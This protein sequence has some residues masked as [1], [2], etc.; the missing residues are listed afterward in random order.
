MIKS[1]ALVP[2]LAGGFLCLLFAGVVFAGGSQQ[3]VSTVA[4]KA[5]NESSAPLNSNVVAVTARDAEVSTSEKPPCIDCAED[6]SKLVDPVVKVNQIDVNKYNAESIADEYA[7][8]LR[9]SIHLSPSSVDERIRQLSEEVHRNFNNHNKFFDEPA[10]ESTISPAPS[11]QSVQPTSTFS[12]PAFAAANNDWTPL[13]SQSFHTPELPKQYSMLDIGFV[14]KIHYDHTQEPN[15]FIKSSVMFVDG[16]DM[17]GFV[18]SSNFKYEQTI[19]PS[20][21]PTTVTT[22]VHTSATYDSNENGYYKEEPEEEPVLNVTLSSDAVHTVVTNN[23]SNLL[24]DTLTSSTHNNVTVNKEYHSIKNLSTIIPQNGSVQNVTDV[25]LVPSSSESKL[26][27]EENNSKENEAVNKANETIQV[28]KDMDSG[29]SVTVSMFSDRKGL[30]KMN[31]SEPVASVTP[32]SITVNVIRTRKP[33]SGFRRRSSTT[34]TTSTT[35]TTTTTEAPQI[36]TTVIPEDAM[37]MGSES[38]LDCTTTEGEEVATE[39]PQKENKVV[40]HTST[41][42][43]TTV[44]KYTTNDPPKKGVD[45]QSLFETPI[46]ETTYKVVSESTSVHSVQSS[47]TTINPSKNDDDDCEME[48]SSSPVSTNNKAAPHDITEDSTEIPMEVKVYLQLKVSTSWEELCRTQEDFKRGLVDMIAKATKKEVSPDRVVILNDHEC[49][50]PP[51]EEEDGI[52]VHLYMLDEAGGYDYNLTKAFPAIW[53]S[54]IEKN[55]LKI[56]CVDLRSANNESSPSTG[57]NGSVIA[58]I[59]ITGIAAGCFIILVILMLIMRKR[60]A[61][62][63]YGQRCTPVSLDAYSLDSVS[64]YNS[65]RR[66]GN[67]RASKRSYGNPNFEDGEGP[68][69]QMN[70]AGLANCLNDT[71]AIHEEFALVPIIQARLDE[72]PPG[73]ETKNR[74]A[75]VI[76]L[77]ETRVPLTK[78]GSDPLSE[79]INANFVRGP[80]CAPRYYIAC[81]APMESTVADFWRMIWEQQSKVVLMLTDLEENGVEK[82]ADYMP[83]SE[84]LDCHRLFGDFHVTLK[85]REER[86]K[87]VISTL[88]LKNMETNSWREV[89]HLWYFGWPS[90]GVP[91]EVNA[92]IAFIIEARAFMKGNSGPSVVHCSPGTGRTGTVIAADLC[93]RDFEK[94]RTVDVPKV[95]HRLRRDR[96]GAVQT[97]EQYLLIYQILNLY[98]AKLTGGA[99]ESI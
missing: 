2:L 50:E 81:Q 12:E 31:E 94:S 32:K 68:S 59:A 3:N 46:E 16:G 79:Y 88:Q 41:T 39:V 83:P 38:M 74:Y 69:H 14:S 1:P 77:P 40:T 73:A 21:N 13:T 76:P 60:Q 35:T 75:N 63:S 36:V 64:V 28:V 78:R 52:S 49:L 56:T 10:S 26:L 22:V 87:Y 9:E 92:I 72:L 15:R 86:D 42:T 71:K 8:R 80:K 84:V 25:E 5:T 65:V 47:G 98:A 93:I 54:Q 19:T 61:R 95:V 66:K 99:M 82:C 4:P 67:H 37:A 6:T 90:T 24:N 44:S 57:E 30:L 53:L 34:S 7:E 55:P 20:I 11:E 97:K 58:A 29:Q 48:E 23:G 18:S 51:P 33:S 85:K 89:T 96:A 91:D 43:T 45:D 70:F 27:K 17:T 62:Y